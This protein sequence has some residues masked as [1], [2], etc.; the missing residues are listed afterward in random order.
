MFF[1]RRI[2]WWGLLVATAASAHT[3]P[4]AGFVTPRGAGNL[5]NPDGGVFEIRWTDS[6]PQTTTVLELYA[7]HAALPLF[8][9]PGVIVSTGIRISPS[10]FDLSDPANAYVWHTAGVPPGC[11]HVVGINTDQFERVPTIA[12]GML[13]VPAV[14]DVPPSIWIVNSTSDRVLPD[15]SFLV[16]LEV[17]DPDDPH[18]VTVMYGRN[19]PT[20]TTL[21]SAGSLQLDAGTDTVNLP[22]DLSTAREGYYTLYAEVTSADDA[23]CSTYWPFPLFVVSTPDAGQ[24]DAGAEVPK[25]SGCGCGSSATG[26]AGVFLVPLLHTRRRSRPLPR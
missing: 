26:A 4:T 6:D 19:E 25:T 13:T 20:G 2:P 22:V 7:S 18:R 11:Y 5:P 9:D 12:P 14:D 10:S 3:F 16:R 24:A 17:S 15:G 21:V 23:G 8:V 1:L